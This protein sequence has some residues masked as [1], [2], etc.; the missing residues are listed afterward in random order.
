MARAVTFQLRGGRIPAVGNRIA[1]GG[2][3]VGVVVVVELLT[4]IERQQV[5]DVH[6][7]VLRQPVLPDEL[8]LVE[9]Q[10]LGNNYMSGC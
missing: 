7:A 4:N 8:H 6:I 1:V 10:R 9:R 3:S 5:V 2:Q